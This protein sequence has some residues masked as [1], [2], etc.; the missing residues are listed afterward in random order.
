MKEELKL[1]DSKTF[2]VVNESFFINR[3]FT[4]DR[5]LI[6]IIYKKYVLPLLVYA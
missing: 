5:H 2:S 3:L 1:T 6:V 4:Y